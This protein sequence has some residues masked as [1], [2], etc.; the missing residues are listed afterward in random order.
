M[1]AAAL[2]LRHASITKRSISLVRP[3]AATVVPAQMPQKPDAEPIF[4]Q[5]DNSNIQNTQ[6][7]VLGQPP[8][9]C[10]IRV[11]ASVSLYVRRGCLVSLHGVGEHNAV[12]ISQEWM[13][14][15]WNLAKYGSWRSALFHQLVAPRAFSALAA[16]NVNGGKMASWFGVSARQFRT[17]CLL[18]LDGTQD[19]C[20]IGKHS[21]IAYEG[22]TSLRIQRSSIWPSWLRLKQGESALPS[23]YQLIQG[24]GNAL[25]SGAGSVYTIEL[26]NEGEELVLKGEHLL[27]ISGRTPRDIIEAVTEYRFPTASVPPV[28]ETSSPTVHSSKPTSSS[29][30]FVAALSSSIQATVSWLR[31]AYTTYINGSTKYLRIRGPRFLLVQS[32]HNAFMPATSPSAVHPPSSPVSLKASTST[33]NSK[34]YLSY[35]TV[36]KDASVS[37]QS[38]PNFSKK[39]EEI[40]ALKRK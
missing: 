32:A 21:L 12:A 19:W 17:L 25:L 34:D 3:V 6:F 5:E 24:R 27:A 33:T 9:L 35:V 38:T 20:V 11:P 7:R 2:Q 22:N 18:D 39:V 37:F 14:L 4:G 1:K 36:G 30:A 40:E 26:P 13:G 23:T 16:P 10:S 8:T 28:S 31:H 29:S 15:A